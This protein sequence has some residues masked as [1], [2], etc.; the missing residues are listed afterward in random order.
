M[1]R[2][3]RKNGASGGE[4]KPATRKT[5]ETIEAAEIP[6]AV[7]GGFAVRAWVAQVDEAAVRTTRDVNILIRQ[8]DLPRLKQAMEDVDSSTGKQRAW[9]CFWNL[10]MHRFPFFWMS[11]SQSA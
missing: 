10:P 9:T 1:T 8:D 6:Y 3:L 2:T 7:I 11:Q 4:S 5:V